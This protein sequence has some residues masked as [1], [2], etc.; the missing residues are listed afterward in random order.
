MTGMLVDAHATA[1]LVPLCL[2]CA[3]PWTNTQWLSGIPAL[4]FTMFV[5]MMLSWLCEQ[6]YNT[7]TEHTKTDT[8]TKE[9]AP[10][11]Q[12]NYIDYSPRALV[13]TVMLPVVVILISSMRSC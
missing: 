10:C 11:M 5:V 2:W 9:I 3:H 6:A 8:D 13:L 4:F 1:V 7:T 12:I